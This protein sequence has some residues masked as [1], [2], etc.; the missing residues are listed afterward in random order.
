MKT[1]TIGKLA[2]SAGTRVET[3]RYYERKGLLDQPSRTASGYRQYSLDAAA[4]LRFIRQA[5][6]LGFSLKEIGELLSM[7]ITP[8]T[9]CAD[10]KQKAESKIAN[11]DDKMASL[12]KMKRALEK[13]KSECTGR[14]PIGEC[15]ILD[16]LERETP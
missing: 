1:L 8:A 5:Q 9:T 7:K 10:I 12:R 11:I 2:R 13:L 3:I 4:R 16:A 15:P 14:G 6:V